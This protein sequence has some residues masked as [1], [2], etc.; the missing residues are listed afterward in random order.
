VPR[1]ASWRRSGANGVEY[2]FLGS[3]LRGQSAPTV[4]GVLLVGRSELVH[5]VTQLRVGDPELVEGEHL[6]LGIADGVGTGI[7][8]VAQHVRYRDDDEPQAATAV[9][10]STLEASTA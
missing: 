2:I 4:R 8:P 6:G 7:G 1:R 9:A 3:N 5:H 10:A